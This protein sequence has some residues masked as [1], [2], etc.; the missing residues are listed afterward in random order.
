MREDVTFYGFRSRDESER[1]RGSGFVGDAE[2]GGEEEDGVV[3]CACVC[4][5]LFL[6][7]LVL[8]LK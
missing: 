4:A 7:V 5:P 8:V 3:E 6:R 1:E 2:S